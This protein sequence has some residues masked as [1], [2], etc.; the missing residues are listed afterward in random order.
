MTPGAIQGR[1]LTAERMNDHNTFDAPDQV[2]PAAFEGVARQGNYITITL[3]AKSV[4]VLELN[5]GDR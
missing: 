4:L 1:V 2:R 5:E 3:P